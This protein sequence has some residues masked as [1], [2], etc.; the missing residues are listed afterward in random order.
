MRYLKISVGAMV[1]TSVV[2]ATPA[3][4]FAQET[5]YV[6]YDE[7]ALGRFLATIAGVVALAGA[8]FAIFNLFRTS[9]PAAG[10]LKRAKIAIG[11][12]VAA[13]VYAG[14]HLTLFTGNFG[15]GDGRAGAILAIVFGL[16]AIVCGGLVLAK[17]RTAH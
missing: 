1:M 3:S 2:L 7:F 10:K 17:T 14:V 12:G 6:G 9:K 13:C 4:V 16:I 8:A 15:A 11:V 5:G